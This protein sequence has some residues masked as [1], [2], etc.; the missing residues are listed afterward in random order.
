M[1]IILKGASELSDPTV[2]NPF[3]RRFAAYVLDM[4]ATI[5][6]MKSI[7][8]TYEDFTWQFLKM[9]PKNFKKV[10]IVADTYK[11]IKSG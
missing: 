8:A 2:E 4:I 3:M 6:M 7:P 9:I 5:R 11:S 1:K 10:G